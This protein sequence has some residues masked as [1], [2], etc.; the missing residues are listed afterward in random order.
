MIFYFSGTGNT[1]YV[2]ERVGEEIHEE[3]VDIR[4]WLPELISVPTALPKRWG[5]AFPVYGWGV[6]PVVADF[7]DHLPPSADEDHYVFA[8]LT[9]GDE[10]GKTHEQLRDLL[11]KKGYTL[12]LVWSVQ[13]PNTYVGFPFFDVD[14]E[15][16]E[17]VKIAIADQ[18]SQRIARAILF[19]E[20]RIEVEQGSVPTLRSGLLRR[21][22]YRWL[23][24]PRLFRT[25]NRCT[26]CHRCVKV[27]PMKNVTVSTASD[28]PRWGDLCAFCMACY[29]VCPVQN[30]YSLP[31][32]KKKGQTCRF[33]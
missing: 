9:C 31:S 12:S 11:S 28:G 16:T 6:P 21:A 29:H 14:S 18:Q 10:V 26:G 4:Q 30:I 20:Q 1:R 2:A 27:C 17:K 19:R 33:L 25:E 8:I 24:S 23:V 15:Q 22:F 7:I 32:G 5:I 13:M 3:A